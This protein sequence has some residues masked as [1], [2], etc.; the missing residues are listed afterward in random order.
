MCFRWKRLYLLA[1]ER[2]QRQK[3]YI[4]E[5]KADKMA[6][7]NIMENLKNINDK[8]GEDHVNIYFLNE[9]IYYIVEKWSLGFLQD[10]YDIELYSYRLDNTPI[11]VEPVAKLSAT[12]KKTDKGRAIHL[13]SIN[14]MRE[15]RNG[16]GSQLLKRL[17]S[18]STSRG[19]YYINGRLDKNTHIG[20]ENL[21]KFYI[22]NGFTIKDNKFYMVVKEAAT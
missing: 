8:Q 16:H 6:Y 17:V 3:E 9:H 11:R 10:E 12:W 1:E 21:E 5:M 15:E 7:D 2:I 4:R 19:V 14:T 20:L 18:I 22:K 13:V